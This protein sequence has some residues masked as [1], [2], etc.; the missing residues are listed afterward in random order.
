VTEPEYKGGGR[1][2]AQVLSNL[3]RHPVGLVRLWNWK[4]AVMSSI[5]RGLVFFVA[6]L[7]AGPEAAMAALTTELWFRL[8]TSGLYGALT[9]TLREVEPARHGILAGMVLL[10]IVSHSLEFAVHWLRGTAELRRSIALSVVFTMISTAFNVY[11]MRRGVLV[12]GRGAQ[13]L[14]RDLL[15]IPGLILRFTGDIVA[16]LTRAAR[17]RIRI[18]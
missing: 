13:P 4:S 8:L 10:P 3:V 18:A 9:E 11:A 5:S 6:N 2:L 15:Q 16:T 7:S 17:S 1:S 14:H 12:V